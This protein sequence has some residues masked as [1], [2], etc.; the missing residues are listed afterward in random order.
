MHGD[1]DQ[2]DRA[3]LLE[4]ARTYVELGRQFLVFILLSSKGE[5]HYFSDELF[6]VV[7]DILKALNIAESASIAAPELVRCYSFMALA[8]VRVS[9]RIFQFYH[10]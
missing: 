4:A 1:Y 6:L 2:T 5:L 3:I 10:E 7:V 9:S 8:T